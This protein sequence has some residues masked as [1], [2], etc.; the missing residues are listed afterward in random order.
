MRT[1]VTGEW[2]TRAGHW[3]DMLWKICYRP[4]GA[5]ALRGF[6]TAEQLTAEQA[7][8]REFQ[9]MPPGTPWGAK[10]EYGWFA[11]ELTL[12]EEA[13]GR[14][15]VLRAD[16]GAESLVWVNGAIVGAHDWG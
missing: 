3:R 14:R 9:P 1:E 7:L 5:L 2:R 4:L 15:I 6:A 13:A 10:W 12:P 11:G 16:A 8:R